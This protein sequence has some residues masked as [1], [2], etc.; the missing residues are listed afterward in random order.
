MDKLFYVRIRREYLFPIGFE[1]F[2]SI[3]ISKQKEVYTLT[4]YLYNF[5]IDCTGILFLNTH[6]TLVSDHIVENKEKGSIIM[7]PK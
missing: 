6:S 4:K 2:S 1:I 7:P 3:S 5:N